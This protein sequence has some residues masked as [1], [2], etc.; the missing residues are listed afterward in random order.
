[1]K[2]Y[3]VLLQTRC[4]LFARHCCCAANLLQK[5]NAVRVA[6]FYC[7]YYY[8]FFFI[9]NSPHNTRCVHDITSWWQNLMTQF[10]VFFFSRTIFL[11]ALLSCASRPAW[12]FYA[13]GTY[14][15]CTY[16]VAHRARNTVTERY[17]IVY[18]NTYRR[19]LF[20]YI[21][22][23]IFSFFFFFISNFY[24]THTHTYIYI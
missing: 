15:Y 14:S 4:L 12:C 16:C 17:R 21:I 23:I 9:R 3:E 13:R 18:R 19:V 6:T 10:L 11:K 24:Y 8:Y 20:G 1:M 22:I 5:K 2:P 7:Y